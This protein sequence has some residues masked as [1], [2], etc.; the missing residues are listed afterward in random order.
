MNNSPKAIVELKRRVNH[1]IKREGA[2]QIPP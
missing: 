2:L 1:Y